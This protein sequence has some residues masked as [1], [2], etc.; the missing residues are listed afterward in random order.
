MNQ[1]MKPL[2]LLPAE[3]DTEVLP[4]KVIEQIKKEKQSKEKFTTSVIVLK[5]Q[6]N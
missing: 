3:I 2:T 4:A 5:G 1:H 6:C